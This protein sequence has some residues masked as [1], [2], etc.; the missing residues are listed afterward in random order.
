MAGQ[1]A[2]AELSDAVT[3]GRP[4]SH[5]GEWGAA[6]L[7]T[8]LAIMESAREHKEVFPHHQVPTLSRCV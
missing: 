1:T 4:V 7:Q 5:S 3:G 6:T 8:C 2:V